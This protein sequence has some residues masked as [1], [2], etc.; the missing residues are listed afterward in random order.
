[1]SCRLNGCIYETL[2]NEPPSS[3]IDLF[4]KSLL[5]CCHAARLPLHDDLLNWGTERL[6]LKPKESLAIAF[7]SAMCRCADV[8]MLVRAFAITTSKR[9]VTSDGAIDARVT[10]FPIARKGRD[11]AAPQHL[12]VSETSGR[13]G[14]TGD[15]EGRTSVVRLAV[16]AGSP[17]GAARRGTL[18]AGDSDANENFHEHYVS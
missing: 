17:S 11:R 6:R 5:E 1:M 16:S 2:R 12:L 13:G 15:C 9:R 10:A 14:A 7:P 8:P 18:P 3:P 4:L